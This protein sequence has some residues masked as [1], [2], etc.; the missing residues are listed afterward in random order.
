V[1][2]LPWNNIADNAANLIIINDDLALAVSEKIS[3]VRV[4][5]K[6][7]DSAISI[8]MSCRADDDLRL[9]VEK[10]VRAWVDLKSILSY[11][12]CIMT[13]SDGDREENCEG[14]GAKIREVLEGLGDKVEYDEIQCVRNHLESNANSGY[15]DSIDD[16]QVDCTDHEFE[17]PVMWWAGRALKPDGLKTKLCDF[18]NLTEKSCISVRI[19]DRNN[20]PPNRESR[21][22]MHAYNNMLSYI[23]SRQETLR[24][25]QCDDDDSYLMSEWTNPRGLK[26]QLIGN[27]GEINWRF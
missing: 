13:Y 19:T 4:H 7:L 8:I 16:D 27:R 14:V 9:I 1:A 11:R 3:M 5:A 21:I 17:N 18:I 22:D 20:P 23:S 25:L 15:K 6:F 24:K 12:D 10:L 26:N 2:L